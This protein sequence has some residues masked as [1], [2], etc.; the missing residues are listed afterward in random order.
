MAEPAPSI[1]TQDVSTSPEVEKPSGGFFSFFGKIVLIL[2][3]LLLLAGGGV[4]VLAKQMPDLVQIP[5][6]SQFLNP[7]PS[8]SPSSSPIPVPS[9]SVLAPSPISTPSASVTTQAATQ[10]SSLSQTGLVQTLDITTN[11]KHYSLKAPNGWKLTQNTENYTSTSEIGNG[12]FTLIIRINE[13]TEGVPCGFP[14]SPV[15]SSEMF[16]DV[17]SFTHNTF[18]EFKGSQNQIFRRVDITANPSAGKLF[19]AVCQKGS[20]TNDWFQ[21]TDFGFVTYEIPY[22]EK[23]TAADLAALKTLD[24]MVASLQVK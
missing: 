2:L 16:P 18:V 4:Y 9:P 23:L 13:A 10:S 19:F 21:P 22:T 12:Q 17:S 5:F 11:N 20:T 1:P 7:N 8:P 24:S 6:L 14:D 15:K 3:I